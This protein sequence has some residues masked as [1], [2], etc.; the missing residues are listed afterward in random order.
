[1][2]WLAEI[3]IA[4]IGV[5]F[6]SPYRFRTDRDWRL[7]VYSRIAVF[8]SIL[9]AL[10]RAATAGDL[11]QLG[12]A[13]AQQRMAAGELSSRELVRH[14][15]ARIERYDDAG[16]QI[17][18]VIAIDPSALAQARARD[19]ERAA[20]QVRGPLHGVPVLLKDNID[21]ADLPTT[22]GSL[23]LASHRPPR[24]A[25]IVTRLRAAGAVILGKT[26]LSEWANFRSTRSSSGWSSVGGQTRNPYDPARN[27]CGSSSG[28]GAAIAADF[29]LVGVGTETDGSIVCP[30]GANGLVGIKPTVGLVSRAGIIPISASQDTAGPMARRVADAAALLTVLAGSD[31]EDAATALADRHRVDYTEGLASAS[32][33][34]VRIGVLRQEFGFHPQVDA[35]MERQLA[36]LREAGAVLIDPVAIDTKGIGAAEFEVLLYEFKDGLDRYLEDSAAPVGSLAALIAFNTA[37]ADTVMPWFGQELLLQAQAKGPLTER[38]YRQ[39]QQR[40]RRLAGPRG[41]DAAL[42]QHRLDALLAPTNGPAWVTDHVNGDHFGGGSSTL[43]AVA[44]Y[45]NVTVPAGQVH[46][47]PVGVSFFGAAWSEAKLIAIAQAH[48]QAS[49]ARRAPV[50]VEAR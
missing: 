34:G 44:G 29:A 1:M 5:P 12:I 21:T 6:E 24:D 46:G 36:L 28:T 40:A 11:D 26:N 3:R 35:L 9:L 25:A 13:A 27:P 23:A 19:A 16:P 2:Q 49:R 4:S 10:A 7:D 17:N 33:R 41:I 48:E 38:A 32:L 14:Y 43:A 42:K 45:P 20:G 8:A 37:H 50:M 22:A 39:A 30:S 15:L 31:R 47:L 18:A